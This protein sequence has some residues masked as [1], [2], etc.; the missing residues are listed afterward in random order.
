M[1]LSPSSSSYAKLHAPLKHN[2]EAHT[3]TSSRAAEDEMGRTNK[4]SALVLVSLHA[5]AALLLLLLL[6]GAR[7]GYRLLLLFFLYPTRTYV[8]N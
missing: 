3:G 1:S 2:F 5:I 4:S 6:P 7:A 8:Q